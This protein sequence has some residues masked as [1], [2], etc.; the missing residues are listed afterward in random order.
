MRT[1]G[2]IGGMSWESSIVYYRIIN[3][4]VRERLGG[5]HSAK[6]V[7]WSFDFD[8][9]TTLQREGD[10]GRATQRMIDAARAIESAGAD[11]AVICTNTMHKMAD[12]VQQAIRIPLIHIADPTAQAVRAANIHTVGLLATRFTME[13]EFYTGRLTHDH[14]LEALVPPPVARQLVHEIIFGELC[15]GIVRESSRQHLQVIIQQLVAAGA[16]AVILGC[17][18]LGLLLQQSDCPVPL[19]DTTVL[20]AQAAADFALDDAA[21]PDLET[22]WADYEIAALSSAQL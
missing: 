11:V 5:L 4:H 22:E 14:G 6:C 7:M 21:P 16:G 15:R 19:F 12:E 8:E 2:L 13:H 20:H 18:E 9:I 3:E 10:W 1:I 17:T